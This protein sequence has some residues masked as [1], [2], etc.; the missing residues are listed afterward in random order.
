MNVVPSL[1]TFRLLLIALLAV[2]LTGGIAFI[3]ASPAAA[4]GDAAISLQ[5]SAADPS[6]AGTDPSGS[7]IY[8]RGTGLLPG[9]TLSFTVNTY[10]LGSPLARIQGVTKYSG[11]SYSQEVPPNGEA[12]PSIAFP[13]TAENSGAPSGL[14]YQM[15]LEAQLDPSQYGECPIVEPHSE[16]T[17]V[18]VLV[19]SYLHILESGRVSGSRPSYSVN[20]VVCSY[21]N[22]HQF[23][24]N[25]AALFYRVPMPGGLQGILFGGT[26]G[27]AEDTCTAAERSEGKC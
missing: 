4:A 20:D 24:S 9:S 11:G 16:V 3:K 6:R 23:S 15:M 26:V 7:P 27:G 13:T 5:V 1:K 12:F 25:P 17:A 14:I 22:G 21:A 10:L 2:A 18:R 19:D 8:I